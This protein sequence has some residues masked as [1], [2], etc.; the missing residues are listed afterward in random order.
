[1]SLRHPVSHLN[2][3]S[4]MSMDESCLIW[5]SHGSHEWARARMN[6]SCAKHDVRC[7]R[8]Q[9]YVR[10]DSFIW[11]M[12][13]FYEPWLIPMS[14]DLSMC[15]RTHP[16]VR[17]DSSMCE[18]WNIQVRHDSSMCEPWLI[19]MS[20]DSILWAMTHSYEPWLSICAMCETWKIQV[21]HDSSIG[22][23][24]YKRWCGTFRRQYGVAPISRLLKI[25]CLFCKRAL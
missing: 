21:R 22:D 11:A 12:T 25:I 3:S 1:M 23:I 10:H 20:H 8:M 19:P 15:A 2:G 4:F 13:H 9:S 7:A 14:H 17:H 6:E 16:C 18:T 5:M 24:M